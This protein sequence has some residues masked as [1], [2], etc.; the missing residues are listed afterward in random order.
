MR[1]EKVLLTAG[2]SL[3]YD[4]VGTFMKVKSATGAFKV[5]VESRQGGR[6]QYR[7]L[8]DELELSAGAKPRFE[9]RFDRVTFVD[10]SGANNTIVLIVGA[11]DHDDDSV[12][13]SVS[14]TNT[15]ASTVDSLPDVTLLTATSH[16]IAADTTVREWMFEA[17]ELNTA[18][19]RI[20]DQSGT[21]DE[22]KRLKPGETVIMSAKGALRVRNNTGA[23]QTFSI[24]GLK[25]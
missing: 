14:V 21:T 11:G 6:G 10:L 12:T 19:L 24:L 16:D 18:A 8:G 1:T 25:G 2:Q 15:A 23:N 3:G 4:F 9:E 7:Q 5:K 20:R 17:D 13:G 22:G